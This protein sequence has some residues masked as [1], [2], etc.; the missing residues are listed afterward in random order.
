MKRPH[1]A[2]SHWPPPDAIDWEDR[3]TFSAGTF[4]AA[5]AVILLCALFQIFTDSGGPRS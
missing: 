4:L 2:R 3:N 5:L 1:R